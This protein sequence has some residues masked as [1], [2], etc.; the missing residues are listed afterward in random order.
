LTITNKL[1]YIGDMAIF[2]LFS[3]GKKT[4]KKEAAKKLA[5]K[6]TTAKKGKKK[7]KGCEFC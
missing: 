7:A 4:P 2:G 1:F 3:S 5:K 6:V